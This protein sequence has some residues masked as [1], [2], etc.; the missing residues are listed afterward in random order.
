MPVDVTGLG[1]AVATVTLNSP[2]RLNAFDRSDLV[3]AQE[4]LD[5]C[6]ADTA[7]RC[8]VLRGA[9]RGFCAGADLDF[10]EGIRTGPRGEQRAGLSLAPALLMRLLTFPKPTVAAV[11]GAAFGGGACLALACDEVLLADDARLGLVFTALGIPGGDMAA[12]WLL[13]RRVGSRRAWRLLATAA[14]L[15]AAEAAAMGLADAVVPSAELTATACR[16][17]EDYAAR[18]PGALST[19]KRQLLR[20]EGVG[21]GLESALAREVEDLLHAMRGADMAEGLAAHREG[22]PPRWPVAEG[23]GRA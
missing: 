11:H 9:G 23:G 21:A 18:S 22:R 13:T 6:E 5:A 10:V 12:T 2:D 14:V 3:A 15:S 7:V 1:T 16:R 8:V 4:A 17:A 19:T 20:L